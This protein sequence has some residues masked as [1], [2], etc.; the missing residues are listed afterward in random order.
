ML[1]RS[2][3]VAA[4][5]LVFALAH[6][7][8]LASSLEDIDSVNFALGVRHFDVAQHQ[9]HPPG[10]PIY[11]ALGKAAKA[12]AG[13]VSGGSD[14]SREA[15]ALAVLSL[16]SGLVSILCFYN[17]FASLNG[18]A[19]GRPTVGLRPGLDVGALSA[20]AIMASCPLDR[21]THV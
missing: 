17:V 6:V 21:K 12:V 11:M 13:A 20:T 18:T 4:L 1:F 8:F 19:H 14:A 9:P 7:P 15:R 2:R 10:Y 16:L 3:L 5:A